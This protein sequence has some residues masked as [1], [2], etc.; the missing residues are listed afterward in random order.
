MYR[1][2]DYISGSI[3]GTCGNNLGSL[4]DLEAELSVLKL[5]VEQRLGGSQHKLS[6][7]A[8]VIRKAYRLALRAVTGDLLCDIQRAVKVVLHLSGNDI[9]LVGVG[10]I[11]IIIRITHRRLLLVNVVSISEAVIRAGELQIISSGRRISKVKCNLTVSFR[12][13]HLHSCGKNLFG[14]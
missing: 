12:S 10:D 3:T 14:A 4:N 9:V 8:V 6:L 11:C 7:N 2:K 5:P 13:T 1:R